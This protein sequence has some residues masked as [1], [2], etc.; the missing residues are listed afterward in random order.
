MRLS[1]NSQ[2]TKIKPTGLITTLKNCIALPVMDYKAA[3]KLSKGKKVK[4]IL[5]DHARENSELYSF[6]LY[7]KYTIKLLKY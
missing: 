5:I 7:K 3:A 1:K 2:N 4:T 6:S